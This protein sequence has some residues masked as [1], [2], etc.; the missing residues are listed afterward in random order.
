MKIIDNCFSDNEL[1]AIIHCLFDKPWFFI[2]DSNK[3]YHKSLY[4]TKT[5]AV[6]KENFTE[7]GNLD[8]FFIE[9][10]NHIL[11][12][13]LDPQ[14]MRILVNCFKYGDN[15]KFHTDN[16]VGAPTFL[17]FINPEWKWWWGSSLRIKNKFFTKKVRPK[18]GRLVI[19]DGS[20]EHCGSPPNCFY[21]G[22]GRFSFVIQYQEKI[23]F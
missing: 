20:K 21:R 23:K 13:R 4:I 22:C 16:R 10:L 19:F 7:F 17:F 5:I 15:P 6:S 8:Y 11:N 14:K 9:K 12:Q 3:E 2:D 18:P 1:Y